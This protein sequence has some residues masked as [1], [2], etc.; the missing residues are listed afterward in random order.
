M[1]I[2]IVCAGSAGDVHPFIAI[3]RALQQRGHAVELMTAAYFRARVERAGIAFISAAG[4]DTFEQI[5]RDAELWHPR[6]AAAMRWRY[7]AA[8]LPGT[9]AQIRRHVRPGETVLV[10]STLAFAARLVQERNGVPMATVHLSPACLFSAT[11]P[12]AWPGLSWLGGLP[13]WVVRALIALVERLALDPVVLP[14]LNGFRR[15]IGLAPVRSVMRRWLHSP[16]RVIC[17][18]P[19]WYAAAQSDWPPHTVATGFALLAAAEGEVMPAALAAFLAAG[20]PPIAFTPGSAMAHGRAFWQRALAACEAM[21]MRA[22]LVTPFADQ[23]PPSLPPFALHAAW[24]PFDLLAP[25][26]AVFVHHGGIGT[27]A[28]VLAAGRP[29][30]VTPFAH[31]QFDNAARL[32]RLGVAA[33]VAHDAPLEQWVAALSFLRDD[34]GTRDACAVMATRMAAG[35]AAPE[36]IAGYIEALA[37]E[38][39]SGPGHCA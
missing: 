12:P 5:L 22:I 27:C 19:H 28:Q 10:A 21:G 25:R 13:A 39:G 31:D 8:S 9:Y 18:F 6:R 1:H 16:Q 14:A 38:A 35:R 11:D 7:V 17:A 15:D 20:P 37:D 29:Q 36:Q 23:L 33:S 4:P 34:A 30:L 2:L 3:A 26:V 24:V 32:T